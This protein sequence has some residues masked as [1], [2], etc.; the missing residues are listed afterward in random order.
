M[1]KLS[2]SGKRI[3]VVESS[4]Q[5]RVIVMEGDKLLRSAALGT[6]KIRDLIWA[7]ESNLLLNVARKI[8]LNVTLSDSVA[9]TTTMIML[10]LDNKPI[11]ALFE[12]DKAIFA[13]VQGFYGFSGDGPRYGYFTAVSTSALPGIGIVIPDG[14]P[15]LYRVD[16]A[17]RETTIVDR[18][19]GNNV[20]RDWLLS[21]QGEIRATLDYQAANGDWSIRNSAEK[22]L[23]SGRSPDD[24]VK[25]ISLGRNERSIAYRVRG[26]DGTRRL[27][28]LPLDGGPAVEP[29]GGEEAG[30][31]ISDVRSGELI[32][33][34]KEQDVVEDHFFDSQREKVVATVRKSFSGRSAELF[35]WSQRFDKL[36]FFTSGSQDA[37]SWWLV[38]STARTA[39]IV[40]SAY[41]LEAADVGL[42]K[43]FR[44]RAADGLNLTGVLTLPP[45]G[46]AKNLPLIVLPHGTPSDRDFPIFH[47]WAQAFASRGYAVFQP[48]YRGS[49]APSTVPRFADAGEWGRKVQTDIS[50]GVAALA[51]AGI[52][53]Q[54]RACI[55]GS[56]HGGYA[57]LAGVTL[58]QGLYR[59]AISV[60]GFGDVDKLLRDAPRDAQGGG[61]LHREAQPARS[62]AGAL[63]SCRFGPPR[64]AGVPPGRSGPPRPC[65]RH[66]GPIGA[67][68]GHRRC[69]ARRPVRRPAGPTGRRRR[70]HRNRGG[71]PAHGDG[72]GTASGR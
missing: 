49:E 41:P 18:P 59:C 11:W 66:S 7:G 29:L 45:V 42:V 33:F 3:A 71:G 40:A 70:P 57:A 5:R 19:P 61:R 16:L 37:G 58:Q 30:S 48:N 63:I 60:G 26:E 4:D 35:D 31:Y 25:L 50:D 53:D 54:R 69:G 36:L 44:Y 39:S 55:A 27:F 72:P 51:S 6:Q 8:E 56:D 20:R 28:E 14:Q 62:R 65:V 67:A 23:A 38:D 22:V 9:E 34:T 47:W 21:A 52:V 24:G 32:G 10:P 15:A 12:R 46:D 68:A 1:V 13:G 64:R 17:T 2:P 43:T